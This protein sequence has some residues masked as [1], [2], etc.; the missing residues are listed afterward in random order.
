MPDRRP[1]DEEQNLLATRRLQ[2][3]AALGLAVLV[4]IGIVVR[5]Q[6]SH[7][8]PAGWWRHW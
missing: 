4:L 8:L 2:V 5:A 1:A 3:G 6:V 7:M